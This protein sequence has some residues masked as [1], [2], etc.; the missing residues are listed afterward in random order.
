MLAWVR[1][2]ADWQT[3]RWLAGNCTSPISWLRAP[4]LHKLRAKKTSSRNHSNLLYPGTHC[5][6]LPFGF[7]T[8]W[9]NFT[10]KTVYASSQ[11]LSEGERG[12][13]FLK[14]RD[15]QDLNDLIPE[16]R[17]KD[18]RIVDIK[19]IPSRTVRLKE[20][21][22]KSPMALRKERLVFTSH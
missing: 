14:F 4:F 8:I 1:A 11:R 9:S 3:Q 15:D 2:A 16:D 6:C 5:S 22:V 10:H 18:T 13:Q 19:N 20:K 17:N 7:L 21:W 12:S